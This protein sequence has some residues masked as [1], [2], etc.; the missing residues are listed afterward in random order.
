LEL[1]P[2][3]NRFAVG[4]PVVVDLSNRGRGGLAERVTV[5]VEGLLPVP[6]G[7]SLEAAASLPTAGVTA[8][9][10]LQNVA[11]LQ[12]GERLLIDGASGGV[13]G[14]AVQLAKSMGAEVTAVVGRGKGEHAVALG[15][16]QVVD[17]TETDPTN[18]EA[19]KAN[20]SG[21]ESYDVIYTVNGHRSLSAY[22][23]VL[24][25]T[26]RFVMTGGSGSLMLQTML[27]GRR[28]RFHTMKPREEDLAHL[29]ELLS[30]GTLRPNIVARYPLARAGEALARLEKGHVSGKIIISVKEG[31]QP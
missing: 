6:R 11:G 29:L 25:P 3:V 5:D 1:G 10:A 4:D 23:R 14:F 8:L 9:Q 12:T 19:E 15:A 22:Q 16:D 28:Y 13:G 7:V 18:P 31:E 21:P 17:Y 27:A 30:D 24:S 2:G 26:G 20:G